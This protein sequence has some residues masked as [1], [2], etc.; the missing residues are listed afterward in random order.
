MD[1]IAKYDNPEIKGVAGLRNYEHQKSKFCNAKTAIEELSK[2]ANN[3]DYKTLI[4]SY[5]TEGIMKKEDI[6]STLK[7]CGKVELIEFE[8]LRFKSNNNGEAKTKKFILEQLFIL[9]KYEK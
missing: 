5:N 6:V 2:I 8:Y 3:T 9:Q 7:Q 1:T 4:L